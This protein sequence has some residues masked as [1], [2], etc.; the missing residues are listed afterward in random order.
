[1]LVNKQVLALIFEIAYI[2]RDT[3]Q[4]FKASMYNVTNIE[5]KSRQLPR[6]HLTS[7]N[8]QIYYLHIYL[9][10]S[11]NFVNEGIDNICRD[12]HICYDYE[13]YAKLL[14]SFSRVR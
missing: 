14:P 9:L 1:M 5:H 8:P 6:S 7:D 12:V 2:D 11:I 3:P 4:Y 13:H 10:R